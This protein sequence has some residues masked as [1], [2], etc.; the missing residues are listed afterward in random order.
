MHLCQALCTEAVVVGLCTA[1][2]RKD[3]PVANDI[4]YC[5]NHLLRRLLM[6]S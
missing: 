2:T 3:M 6:S 4:D 1:L 5:Y